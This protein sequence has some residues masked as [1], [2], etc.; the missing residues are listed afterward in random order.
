MTLTELIDF[1]K[2]GLNVNDSQLND[3]ISAERWVTLIQMAY[4]NLWTRVRNQV[5]RANLVKSYD[6]SWAGGAATY[7]LPQQYQNAVIY[8]IVYTDGFGNPLS[9]IQGNFETRNVFRLTAWGGVSPSPFTFRVYYIPEV[10][11]L[12]VSAS[13]A[14]LPP[15]HHEAIAWEALITVK[16]FTDK[17]VPDNWAEHRD[18]I[19]MMCI[20][21][22]SVRPLTFR[23]NIVSLDAPLLRPIN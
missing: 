11:V 19:E 7:T 6:D 16:M 4:K 1:A 22:L 14:L 3:D 5:G 15:A 18:G 8:D 23:A 10:E 20:K 21:E 2:F 13:P 12:T 9:R 17:K